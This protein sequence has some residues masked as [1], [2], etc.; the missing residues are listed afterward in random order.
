[1][2]AVE[3][4][5]LTLSVP[6]GDGTPLAFHTHLGGLAPDLTEKALEGR[7]T[8]LL[9]NGIGTTENFWR[10]LVEDFQKDYRV[11][12]WDYRGHG[13]SAVS[14]SGDY[15]FKTQADDLARVT[16]AVGAEPAPVQVA[17]SM[18]VAV[19]LEMYRTHPE[20]ASAMVLI[21]GAPDAPG[22]GTLPFRI[23][24]VVS[25]MRTSMAAIGP[26]VPKIA[27]VAHAVMRSPLVYPVGRA[28]GVLRKRAPKRDIDLFMRG[29]VQMDPVAYFETLRGLMEARASD[30]LPLVKVP[31]LIIAAA[32]DT[33][34]PR[35]QVERMRAAL[36]QAR[37]VEIADAGHA[38]LVEAGPEIAAATREFLAGL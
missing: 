35:S 15:A 22:H 19:L 8:L 30:V 17:F 26:L 24:G 34:M 27:G 33:M 14:V 13:G 28:S 3:Y 5:K 6:G 32:N 16:K 36:P 12:H 20:L 11:V 38:G 18:G 31:V 7:R 10:F 21:A 4:R 37:Y 1:V 23:P 29:L 9:S 25:A 2:R